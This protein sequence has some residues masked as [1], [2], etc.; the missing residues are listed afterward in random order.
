[1]THTGGGREQPL[2]THGRKSMTKK[3]FSWPD[4]NASWPDDN[5]E[6][7]WPD[8][9]EE[10]DEFDPG[11]GFS[12]VCR[13]TKSTDSESEDDADAE[14]V[15]VAI[16]RALMLDLLFE[17]R[18]VEWSA[19]QLEAAAAF[20]NRL[21][22]SDD[23]EY[24]LKAAAS[25][26][27]REDA[28]LKLL[29]DPAHDVRK[30]LAENVDA[31]ALVPVNDRLL[32]T[33]K[34]V[35]VRMALLESALKNWEK[36]CPQDQELALKRRK[37]AEALATE[38]LRHASPNVCDVAA[39]VLEKLEKNEPTV[40]EKD[41]SSWTLAFWN[42]HKQSARFEEL[43]AARSRWAFFLVE[44][45]A[46]EEE[47][48]ELPLPYPA[49]DKLANNLAVS[50]FHDGALLLERLACHPDR[51]IRATVAHRND[52]PIEVY[53]RFKTETDYV[54]REALLTNPN[55]LEVM[56]EETM[57]RLVDN[58]PMLICE[59]YE[60]TESEKLDELMTKLYGFWGENGDKMVEA[61]ESKKIGDVVDQALDEP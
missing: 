60:Q 17:M 15:T 30:A 4:D 21:A 55:A 2:H 43:L 39:G 47:S 23:A 19:G 38:S 8:D 41:T 11:C 28:A 56:S 37:E 14:T 58:D 45:D 12:V 16:S 5:E 27:L 48:A 51:F 9:D 46:D 31:Q 35:D 53:A 25:S 24:R 22:D 33:E 36:A 3:D 18:N 54:V 1:M 40:P 52:V 49:L 13:P 61:L 6:F 10:E 50:E 44:D 7:S 26:L 29:K 42:M 20:F 34:D 57:E 59:A 32:L